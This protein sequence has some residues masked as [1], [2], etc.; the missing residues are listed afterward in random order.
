MRFYLGAFNYRLA[1]EIL[2]LSIIT[3]SVP[4][5]GSTKH[6]AFPT[7]G[8][9]QFRIECRYLNIGQKLLMP[10]LPSLSLETAPLPPQI[11]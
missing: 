2:H 1:S 7:S 8:F 11:C 3:W 5:T 6:N 4:N 10:L 9:I